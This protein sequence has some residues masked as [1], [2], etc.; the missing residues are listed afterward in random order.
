M[1]EIPKTDYILM[2]GSLYHFIPEEKNLIQ[3]LLEA[4]NKEII[5]SESVD[6]LSNSESKIKSFLA[7]QFSKAK[8]GQ[9]KLKF[10]TKT[11]SETFSEFKNQ[12]KVWEEEPDSKEIIIVLKK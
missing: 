7:E 9:S 3:K 6:N 11:L 2:Q 1:D 10:T 12:I 8:T 5:I 4:C